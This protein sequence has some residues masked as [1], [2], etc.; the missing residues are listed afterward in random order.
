LTLGLWAKAACAETDTEAAKRHYREG[1]SHYDLGEFKQ[2]IDSYKAGYRIKS[3]PVFLYNIGQSH[4][5]LKEYDQAIAAY[6]AYLRNRPDAP[7][8]KEVEAKIEDM[9]SEQNAKGGSSAATDKPV[10][11][12]PPPPD[13][14]PVSVNPSNPPADETTPTTVATSQSNVDLSQKIP[15]DDSQ[16]TLDST[17]WIVAGAGGVLITAGVVT[18]LL[19]K[20]R[21]S[22]LESECPTKQGCSQ[23]AQDLQDSGK[24]LA[25]TTD[26]LF[27]AG[28]A[29]VA[30]GVVWWFLRNREA[31]SD[32]G[33][34]Q[35][36]T[37]TALVTV[38]CVP[39]TCGA[40]ATFSF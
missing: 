21:Q 12:I 20:G 39:G 5:M 10:V 28:G 26:V 13:P 14:S 31:P 4:R 30:T 15:V 9:R 19:A 34:D 18:G 24:T 38:S 16:H 3:D 11:V 35:P 6:K 22:D 40:A 27:V 23:K 36:K 29:A 2:A 33:A 7:N 17:P 8:R 25:L 32:G 1:T 37:T